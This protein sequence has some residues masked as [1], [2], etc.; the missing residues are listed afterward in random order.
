ML[1]KTF[2]MKYLYQIILSTALLLSFS[3]VGLTQSLEKQL[4]GLA[5]R[6]HFTYEKMKAD[7]F[8]TEKYMLYVEQP[9]NHYFPEGKKFTQRVILCHKDFT[10]PMVFVTEGYSA[11]YAENPKYINELSAYLDANQVVVEHRYFN[12]SV[13]DTLEWNELTVFNAASDHHRIVE[14]LKHIYTGKWVNTGISK[15]GQTAVYHR[16]FYP[17]DVDATVGYVCPINFSIEDRRAYYFLDTVGSQQCRDKIFTFQQELLKHKSKYLP[18]FKKL[19]KDKKFTYRMGIEKGFEL[20]VFE[21][22]FAFRQWGMFSCNDIPEAKNNSPKEMISFLDKVS[23]LEWISDQGIEKMQPFF[24][25]AMR[26]LG[27]YGYNIEPFKAW[28]TYKHNPNFEFTLPRGVTAHYNPETMRRVDYF[29][30]HQATNM[31]LIYGGGDPWSMAAGEPT[32]HTNSF[33]VIK[34]GG[35]HR[36]RIVNLPDYQ[37]K[38]VLDSLETWLNLKTQLKLEKS[39]N[40]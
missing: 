6:Y 28:T 29:I 12:K 27:M 31:I 40:R 11:A 38:Q 15:G 10:A 17:E 22:S 25:Q 35:S 18:V 1:N 16:F 32:G 37:R 4:G 26:E 14:I 39:L 21:F 9:L 24:Y 23:T 3:T 19:A 34:P 7:T 2:K 8:F 33:R 5:S 20:T 30:R 36:T 13:P